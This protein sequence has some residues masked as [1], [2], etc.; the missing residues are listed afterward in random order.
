MKEWKGYKKG[1]NIGGWF[2]QNDHRDETYDTFITEDDF[3]VISSWGFDHVRISIDYHLLEDEKG[4]RLEKGFERL[5]KAIALCEKYKLNSIIDLHRVYGFS[6]DKSYG[7]SGFFDDIFL[8][9]RFYRLWE[10]IAKRFGKYHGRV[11][12]ELLNEITEQS[13]SD[14]W[15]RI[16]RLCI[17]RIRK[18][19]PETDIVVGSYWNNSFLALSDLD[20]KLDDHIIY[21]FHCYEPLI[22][23]HQGANW[24]DEM[25]VDYRY[26]IIDKTYE[27]INEDFGR[28]FEGWYANRILVPGGSDDP[29][30][31]KDFFISSFSSAV[32]LADKLNVP[33]YCGEYGCIQYMDPK[34][35]LYWFKAIHQAF[36][37]LQIN[38]AVWT[39]KKMHFGIADERLDGVRDELLK[40]L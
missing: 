2:A 26:S 27:Q 1:I 32:A 20:I 16:A 14:R 37:E 10:D 8:Q 34:D 18:I 5:E 12:F 35:E 38:R 6:F 13:Y 36:E 21:T 28:D 40:Y 25:P 23:T 31:G 17:G 4:Q 15:N 3:K 30:F 22:F 29:V 7:E 19:A 39:Y 24:I 9:E 33:L 11:A